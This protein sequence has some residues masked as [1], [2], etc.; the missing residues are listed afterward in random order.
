[1]AQATPAM[2]LD[3]K[4]TSD[5]RPARGRTGLILGGLALLALAAL[6]SWNASRSPAL[7]RARVAESRGNF[8]DALQAALEHLDTRPWSREASRIVARCLSRFDFSEKADPYYQKAGELSQEDR[9]YRA[10]GLVRANRREQ[11]V[12]AYREIL[13]RDPADA[14][15]MR[16]LGGVYL[17]QTRWGELRT[18]AGRLIAL[19]DRPTNVFTP[20]IMAAHWTF[21]RD[22]MVSPTVIGRTMEG[23]ANHN[24]RHIEEAI[25]SFEAVL[26]LD[27]DLKLMPLSKSLFWAQYTDDLLKVGRAADA[28]ARLRAFPE[29]DRDVSLLDVLARAYLQLSRLDDAETTW[30]RALEIAPTNTTALLNIGRLELQRSRPEPASK[31]LA[32]A[33]ELAPQSFEIAYSLSLAYRQLGKVDEARKFQL[34]A[35]ALGPKKVETKP[36]APQAK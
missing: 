21:V 10:Y 32:R 1:M 36:V 28:V 22:Q 33:A 35:A 14:T 34:R 24:E 12:A 15:A 11:A 23:L 17:S 20:K 16:F 7:T 4:P 29:T 8:A 19:P 26:R 6:T 31:H 13:E 27:P 18:L 3:A 9:H 2:D 25:G 30:N 5:P